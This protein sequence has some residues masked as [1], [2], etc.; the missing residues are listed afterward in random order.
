MTTPTP[1]QCVIPPFINDLGGAAAGR[2]L[3]LFYTAIP[4]GTA[5]GYPWGSLFATSSLG[6]AWAFY[7]ESLLMLPVALLCFFLPFTWRPERAPIE[8]EEEDDDETAVVAEGDDV[9]RGEPG[10]NGEERE[11]RLSLERHAP[12][13]ARV[14]AAAAHMSLKDEFLA[15]V[16]R[17]VYLLNV[18][19]YAATTGM[20]IG[21]STFGSALFLE[22][23]CV[24]GC[25]RCGKSSFW[26]VSL[27]S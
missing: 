1:Q 4:L 3:A 15:V 23:G 16:K 7:V 5:I 8:E 11:R 18:F 14:V 22:F 27:P 12:E 21:V 24:C 10:K 17:P 6:W 9:K 13:D 19:G 25:V 2:W 26:V 20:M